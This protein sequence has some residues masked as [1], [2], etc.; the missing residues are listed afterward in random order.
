MV[1]KMTKDELSILYNKFKSFP[2]KKTMK[3]FCREEDIGYE[4]FRSFK[5]RQEDQSLFASHNS[6]T[7]I[8]ITDDSSTSERQIVVS[9]KTSTSSI[10]NLVITYPNGIQLELSSINISALKD[11]VSLHQIK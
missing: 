10:E 5:R 7:P 8:S 11:L 1:T 4:M 6:F 9:S 3:A 2:H